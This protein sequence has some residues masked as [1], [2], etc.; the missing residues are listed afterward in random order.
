MNHSYWTALFV[1]GS[2]AI[3]TYAFGY[4]TDSLTPFLRAAE[5]F[6]FQFNVLILYVWLTKD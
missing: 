5:I 3:G 1:A 2:L 6:W 4:Y